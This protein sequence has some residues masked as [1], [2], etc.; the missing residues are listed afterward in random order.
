MEKITIEE[1]NAIVNELIEKHNAERAKDKATISALTEEIALLREESDILKKTVAALTA[2]LEELEAEM[3]KNSKNSS[4]PPSSDSAKKVK[5][6]QS[7]RVKTGRATGGQKGHPGANLKLKDQPDEIVVL[8]VK[9]A[10]E[11]GGKIQADAGIVEK[12][13]LTDIEPSKVITIEYRAE[14]GKCEICSKVHK[15]SFPEGVN[16]AAVY[17]PGI[18]A[19][20]AY[21]TN[22]QHLPLERAAE[23]AKEIYGIDISQGTIIRASKEVFNQLG[24][25]DLLIKD[26]IINSDVAGFDESGMRVAGSLNW[27]HCAATKN[28]VYYTIHKKRGKEGIDA[29]GI[30]P[31]FKGTAIH[32]HCYPILNNTRTLFFISKNRG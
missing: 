2:K 6:T 7:L 27:L 29:A 22:Y 15:A 16:A 23:F 5:A 19:V 12:R 26:E 3:K 25:V 31:N 24:E 14:E 13:Q 4:K 11:C 18:K 1:H 30:L 17:G 8:Q 32:D 28:A 21:M 10:C 20:L 9:D